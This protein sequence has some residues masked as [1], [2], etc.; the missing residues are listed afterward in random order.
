MAPPG[1]RCWVKAN[2]YTIN[3]NNHTNIIKR[4]DLYFYFIFVSDKINNYC[5]DF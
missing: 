5:T 2:I 4:K 3:E 1:S